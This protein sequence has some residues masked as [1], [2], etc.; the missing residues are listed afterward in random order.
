MRLPGRTAIVTTTAVLMVFRQIKKEHFKLISHFK[1]S[2]TWLLASRV[3]FVA[4]LAKT[5]IFELVTSF[6]SSTISP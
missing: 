1:S 2:V 6:F 5:L 4:V 3:S